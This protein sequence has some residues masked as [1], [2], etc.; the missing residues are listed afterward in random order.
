[1]VISNVLSSKI[2]VD[3]KIIINLETVM[4]LKVF[5]IYHKFTNINFEWQNVEIK[6]FLKHS[7]I[8]CNILDLNLQHCWSCQANRKSIHTLQIFRFHNLVWRKKWVRLDKD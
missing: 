6:Y 7:L 3:K 8:F 5:T 4:N 2:F 1:M